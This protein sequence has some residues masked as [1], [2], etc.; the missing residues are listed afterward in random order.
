M[1]TKLLLT[2]LSF[3]LLACGEERD[4]HNQERDTPSS[5]SA[6]SLL[7]PINLTHTAGIY[8]ILLEWDGTNRYNYEIA[9]KESNE[10]N[11][12]ASITTQESSLTIDH[13]SANS[14]YIFKIRAKDSNGTTSDYYYSDTITTQTPQNQKAVLL[15]HGLDSGASTW[16]VAASKIS[17]VLGMEDGSYVEIG[18]DIEIIAGEKCWDAYAIDELIECSKLSDIEDQELFRDIYRT[19]A[20]EHIFGLDRGQFSIKQ[21]IWRQN[22]QNAST[23]TNRVNKYKQFKKHRVFVINFSNNKQLTYDA[24]GA[25]LKAVVDDI[26]NTLGIKD[27]TL[28]GHS[29]GGLAARAYIQNETTQNVIQYISLNTPHLGGKSLAGLAAGTYTFIG[30]N[31]GVNL[32]S[33]SKALAKLNHIDTL[34]NKYNNIEVYHIGYSDGL[35]D[36]TYYNLSDGIVDIGSQMGL[37]LLNPYRVIFSPQ[38]QTDLLYYEN[39]LNETTNNLA[40]KILKIKDY[41]II[42]FELNV[43]IPHSMVLD[44]NDYINYLVSI[45]Q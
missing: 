20:Q 27:Y 1:Y 13:L 26:T 45:I 19:Q 17:K 24:Q 3:L 25:E 15:I 9:Y 44:D 8:Q 38:Q 43:G 28:V 16:E 37:D 29:M 23:I 5:T 11:W 33:D 10:S 18:V 40:N 21:I 34:W 7:E 36:E 31:A 32:A 22:T 14:N 35:N 41:D 6:T 30:K 2:L 12:S 39:L 42:D 4:S